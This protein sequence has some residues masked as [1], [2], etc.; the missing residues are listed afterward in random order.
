MLTQNSKNNIERLAQD[1]QF[2]PYGLWITTVI[3]LS[4]MLAFQIISIGLCIANT[5]T[6]PVENILGPLGIYVANGVAGKAT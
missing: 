4:I 5:F 3:F 6:V 2:M 1:D